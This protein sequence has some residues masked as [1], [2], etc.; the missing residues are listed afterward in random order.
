MRLLHLV[1]LCLPVSPVYFNSVDR[2]VF[3]STPD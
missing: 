1:E 2:I 3:T